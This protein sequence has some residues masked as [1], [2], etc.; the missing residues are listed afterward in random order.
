VSLRLTTEIDAK[1]I[2]DYFNG[3][4]DGFIQYV[5]LHSHDS[6]VQEG[7]S[8][9]DIVHRLTGRFDARVDIAHYN[10]QHG[11]QPYHRIVRCTFQNIKDFCFDL[12]DTKSYE[13]PIKY[14]DIQ[15]LTIQNE[16]GQAQSCFTLVFA[17]SKLFNNQWTARIAQVL[18]F[19]EAEFSEH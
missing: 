11:T 7:G 9:T 8:V 13:W 5:A 15:P 18:T 16:Q 17:W 1:Q 3:F 19:Q 14:V 2:L 10:Y 4:H 6:F 12:R